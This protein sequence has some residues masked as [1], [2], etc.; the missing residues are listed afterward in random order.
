MPKV[1]SKSFHSTAAGRQVPPVLD[2]AYAFPRLHRNPH[3]SREARG[4]ATQS[5]GTSAS[6]SRGL[7]LL[8]AG[9][10]HSFA[11][12]VIAGLLGAGVYLTTMA[13]GPEARAVRPVSFD[14]RQLAVLIGFGM[15]QVSVTGATMTGTTA[16]LD[17]LEMERAQTL[18][19][20]DLD[21]ATRRIETLPW[22]KRA[23]LTRRF[24]GQLD[25]HIEEREP[26]AVWRDGATLK[27]I[28]IDGRVLGPT[29]G[30]AAA[31]LPLVVG[32][33]APREA[34]ALRILLA[35]FPEVAERFSSAEWV[36]GR[37]WRLRLTGDVLIDLPATGAAAAL[38]RLA[39]FRGAAALLSQSDVA[40]DLRA[41]DRI[42]IFEPGQKAAFAVDPQAHGFAVPPLPVKGG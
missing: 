13:Q 33:D 8:T 28:D 29:N 41:Q 36:A 24:P 40:I 10:R 11:P 34:R 7:A 12:A 20:F 6:G 16:V 3:V 9:L 23:A 1:A 42:T 17:R 18:L 38:D 39:A 19:G 2:D 37:R 4:Q 5:A 22:V 15:D 14:L 21:D 32:S 30:R 35:G 27:L 25:I 31:H 26:F